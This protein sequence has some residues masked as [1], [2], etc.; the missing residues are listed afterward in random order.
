MKKLLEKFFSNPAYVL[1]FGVVSV[2]SWWFL[3]SSV[4]R[5]DFLLLDGVHWGWAVFHYWLYSFFIFRTMFLWNKKYKIIRMTKKSRKVFLLLTGLPVV[6]G[7]M[8][9]SVVAAPVVGL[10]VA[11]GVV[12]YDGINRF[13]TLEDEY[14]E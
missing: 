11:A 9:L 5:L 2:V 12:A 4:E 1:L 14:V 10:V 7:A 13:L 8:F 3:I 6:N